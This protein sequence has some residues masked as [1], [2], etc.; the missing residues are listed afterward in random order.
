MIIRKFYADWCNPCKQMTPIVE[1]VAESFVNVKVENI[2]IEDE[3]NAA[4][5]ESCAVK[6]IPTFDFL[7]DK[8]ERLHYHVGRLTKEQLTNI[9]EENGA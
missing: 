2:N 4:L 3:A 5:M 9:L 7:S 1:E 6:S 8:G